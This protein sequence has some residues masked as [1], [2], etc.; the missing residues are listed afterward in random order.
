LFLDFLC[1]EVINKI[2]DKR[3]SEVAQRVADRGIGIN[4]T[5]GAFELVVRQGYSPEFG[6][7]YLNRTI[8]TLLL[9]P[10][11]KFLLENEGAAKVRIDVNGSG[12]AIAIIFEK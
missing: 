4:I 5:N 2:A 9:K 11:A 8:E 6:A 12:T 1:P 7:R 3:L 10:L